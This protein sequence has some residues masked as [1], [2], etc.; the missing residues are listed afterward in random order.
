MEVFEAVSLL[1]SLDVFIQAVF[2]RQFIRPGI[3]QKLGFKKKKKQKKLLCSFNID[4]TKIN[5]YITARDRSL[6]DSVIHLMF[7]RGTGPS[8]NALQWTPTNTPPEQTGL[9]RLGGDIYNAENGGDAH[10]HLSTTLYL[11]KWLTFWKSC[12]L[13][14]K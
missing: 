9:E 1:H 6:P 4:R 2:A 12:R 8:K 10:A 11:G 13:R 7:Q 3:E 14:S 5:A